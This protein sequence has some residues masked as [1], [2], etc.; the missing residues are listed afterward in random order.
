MFRVVISGYSM[1]SMLKYFLVTISYLVIFVSL[2]GNVMK[3]LIE[4]TILINSKNSSSEDFLGINNYRERRLQEVEKKSIESEVAKI[5]PQIESIDNLVDALTTTFKS[6]SDEDLPDSTIYAVNYLFDNH[7]SIGLS[8]INLLEA[9]KSILLAF[10]NASVDSNNNISVSLPN[11]SRDIFEQLLPIKVSDNGY[12]IP[13]WSRNLSK[14]FIDVASVES[15]ENQ[16]V[17]IYTSLIQQITESSLSLLN[18]S[19]FTTTNFIPN[20]ST[21]E[22][23]RKLENKDMKFA[24]ESRFMKFDPSKTAILQF[25]SRGLS[26]GIY[27]LENNALTSSNI[28][29]FSDILANSI[30]S[31]VIEYLSRLD[32]DHSLFAYESSNA[33][34]TGITLGAVYQVSKEEMN[35]EINIPESVAESIANAL[36]SKV[37]KSS[38]DLGNGYELHRL[39]ESVAFG[40]SMGAQLSTV[41]DKA[42]D[43]QANWELYSRSRLAEATSKGSANGSLN[44]ASQYIQND[45]SFPDTAKTTTR[46]EILQIASGSALG[47]L[48]GNTGLAI[49]YPSTME[50]IKSASQG[51]SSGG[52]TAQ[53]LSMVD[54]PKGI[55]EEFEVEIA[56][57]LAFGASEGALFQIVALQNKS[58]PNNPDF[59][60]QTVKTAESVSFGSAF[61]AVTGGIKSGE[62]P[63]IIKQAIN[64]GITEGSSVGIALALGYDETVASK[65]KTSSSTAI[66]SAIQKTVNEAASNANDSMSV[67]RIQTSSRDM[68]LLMRK[69]N[70]NPLFTNPTKIFSNPAKK[71]EEA[72]KPL[73]DE[74][75]VAS[76]I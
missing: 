6:F 22:P 17:I 50:I 11:L 69:F 68:L 43:Y 61:G 70:I 64:Q 2:R 74:F 7:K 35:R 28:E 71:E 57:A 30:G 58:N 19:A 37:I 36:S 14:V 63:L 48:M 13:D 34:A 18:D 46:K 23:S 41:L 15:L 60:D 45:P 3:S 62:D 26:E 47:S 29:S 59:E 40:T 67:K 54:K 8:E 20:I 31:T 9:I 4:S 25:S 56:R 52:M 39:A 44:A 66:S 75:P 32:G 73:K 16:K 65:V 49:Y 24:G 33:I 27:D 21:V 51:V 76:P 38:L 12:S 1:L 5:T 10:V 72:P 42:L 53:N 55:T